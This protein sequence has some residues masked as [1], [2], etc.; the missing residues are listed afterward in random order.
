M[1]GERNHAIGKIIV[2]ELVKKEKI[3]YDRFIE[4]VN[5]GQIADELLQANVCSYNP[6]SRFVTFQSCA[7]EVFVRESPEFSSS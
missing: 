7:T 5:N 1:E 3:Y 4:L 6:K 2:Q